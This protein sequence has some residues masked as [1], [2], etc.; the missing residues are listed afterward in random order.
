M[1]D[2]RKKE[3]T[4]REYRDAMLAR[5]VQNIIIFPSVQTYNK[6]VDSNLLAN[7]PVTHQ[8]ILAADHILGKNISALKGKTAY[9]QGTPVSG[10]TMEFHVAS[11]YVFSEPCS[12]STYCLSTR[13]HFWSRYPKDSDSG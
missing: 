2:D 9:R 8:D 7:C 12:L 3:Y 13:S 1:V 5:R 6:I 10:R 11:N 4:K